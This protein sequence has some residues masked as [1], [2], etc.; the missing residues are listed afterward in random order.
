MSREIKRSGA[1]LPTVIVY[2]NADFVSGMLQEIYQIGLLESAEIDV[3][4]KHS[5]TKGSKKSGGAKGGASVTAPFVGKTDL[6]A[7]ADYIGDQARSDE[8]ATADRKKFVYSQAFYLDRVR[9]ALR[10]GRVH[11]LASAADADS[12]RI[13]YIV[14]F[15]ASFRANEV[16]AIL[17][18]ATPELTSALTRY[19]TR[20]SGTEELRS[21]SA[22]I[23][24]AEIVKLRAVTELEASDRAELAS[25]VT[26]AVR[27][28][29]RGDRTK[30]FYAEVYGGADGFTAIT[31]CEVEY[32]TTQDSDRL[33]DGKFTVL[34]KVISEV[35]VDRPVLGRNKLLH[36]FDVDFLDQTLRGVVDKTRQR[37][38]GADIGNG[39]TGEYFD[40]S[41]SAKIAGRSLIVMPIAIYV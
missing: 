31:V 38:G 4:T 37:A 13:G 18:V 41:L 26:A 32:F 35:E 34:A 3:Q 9:A 2:Q 33:L 36:R 1:S 28:D 6:S 29:F 22:N 20:R 8:N 27:A 17:D 11:Q 21:L 15:S 16:N 12:A 10:N 40:A 39:Y 19:I 23:D 7:S 30:E 14:E 25:A 5:E 24:H